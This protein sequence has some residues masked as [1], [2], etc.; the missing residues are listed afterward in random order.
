MRLAWMLSGL[1]FFAVMSAYAIIKLE[2][3]VNRP[4]EAPLTEI[5]KYENF[6]TPTPP[7]ETKNLMAEIPSDDEENWKAAENTLV[8]FF[9]EINA[10][11]YTA[12]A[13]IRTPDY[14]IGTPKAYAAQLENS[15]KNDISGKLKITNIEQIG[16]KSKS[17][18]K[19]F[20]F[21]KDVVWSFDNSTH[22]EI[23]KAA[24]V[25]RDGK[26]TIDF[27]EIERKF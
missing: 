3:T 19:Y 25:L 27:F 2:A 1:A 5:D 22:S 12:A 21:Q 16:D 13:A 26:W 10:G 15:M 17:T 11:N 7:A 24:L 6:V 14:L 9:T 23:R 8:N 20:R 18:T 4:R